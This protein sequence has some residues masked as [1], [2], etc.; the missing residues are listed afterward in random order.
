MPG[1]GVRGAEPGAGPGADPAG[2][3]PGEG[4][5]PLRQPGATPTHWQQRLETPGWEGH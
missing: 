3:T 1:E 2:S 5:R 4:L